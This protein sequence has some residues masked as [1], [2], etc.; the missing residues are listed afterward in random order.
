ML[1]RLTISAVTL[2]TASKI[3]IQAAKL[4]Q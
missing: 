2:A 3:I 4:N 1:P